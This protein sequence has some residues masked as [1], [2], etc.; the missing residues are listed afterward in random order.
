MLTASFE[1]GQLAGHRAGLMGVLA[2]SAAVE[3]LQKALASLAQAANW[4]AAN[5]GPAD[6]VV[7]NKT[8]AAVGAVI[9]NIP[10]IPSSLKAL[11]V[12]GI[13]IAQTNAKAMAE[14]KT[15]I[16]S[17]AP[18]IT[19]AVL[20]AIARY[21]GSGQPSTTAPAGTTSALNTLKMRVAASLP[22]PG[23]LVMAPPSPITASGLP[24][25]GATPSSFF[26]TSPTAPFYKKKSTYYIAGGVA[27]AGVIAFLIFR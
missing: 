12:A 22:S 7:G 26:S 5:P 18:Q 23:G 27:A 9:A 15:L 6:G 1:S 11:L 3:N 2:G 20:A 8:V 13:A 21:S 25:Q 19:A 17:H 10:E 4:P 24:S 16:E 14:A